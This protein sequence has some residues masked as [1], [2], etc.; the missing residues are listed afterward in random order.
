MRALALLSDGLAGMGIYSGIGI[1][2]T[3]LLDVARK[4]LQTKIARCHRDDAE[5][6]AERAKAATSTEHA[7]EVA[8]VVLRTEVATQGYEKSEQDGHATLPNR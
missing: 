3:E 5:H 8:V 6:S 7:H 1:V 2:T 4:C